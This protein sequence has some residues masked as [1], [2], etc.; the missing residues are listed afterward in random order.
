MIIDNFSNA[1]KYFPLHALFERCFDYLR[2]S[3]LEDLPSGKVDIDGDNLFAIV[4]R[5]GDSINASKLEVHQRYLDIHYVIEGEDSIGWKFLDACT[6]PIGVFN[7][8]DDY[9]LFND[10]DFHR[11]SLKASEFAI[12]YPNDAHAP[13][14][15]TKQLFKI[16]LK[17]KI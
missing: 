12:V 15:Q 3:Q 13:L 1:N 9:Q 16:V 8:K 5:N 11:F 6:E 10:S 7:E 17:V 14:L 4:S 2:T